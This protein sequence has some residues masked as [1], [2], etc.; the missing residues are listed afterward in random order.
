M[1]VRSRINRAPQCAA[2]IQFHLGQLIYHPAQDGRLKL[3]WRR[4]VGC[5]KHNIDKAWAITAPSTCWVEALA[6]VESR[7]AT[8]PDVAELLSDRMEAMR[9]SDMVGNTSN[10]CP[11]A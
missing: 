2:A 4:R 5:G 10:T 6:G 9:R 8:R 1:A 3:Y 7:A 11:L